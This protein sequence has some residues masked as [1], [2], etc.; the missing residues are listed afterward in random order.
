MMVR[1]A[2]LLIQCHE[3][4]MAHDL[5][6]HMVQRLEAYD[7]STITLYV[8]SI[9]YQPVNYDQTV[10]TAHEPVGWGLHEPVGWFNLN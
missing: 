9:R 4:T 7:H 3:Q 6:A 2:G 5:H 1:V 10:C 8:P